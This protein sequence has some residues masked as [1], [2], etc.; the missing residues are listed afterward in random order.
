GAIAPFASASIGSTS[1]LLAGRFPA[2]EWFPDFARWWIGDAL[3][4]LTVMPGLLLIIRFLAGSSRRIGIP[5]AIKTI[6][7]A[8]LA[9]AGSYQIFHSPG[10]SSLLFGVLV[11]ILIAAATLGVFATR[12]TAFAIGL[13]AIW[14]AHFGNGA[15]ASGNLHENL[16]SLDLF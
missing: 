14:A 16:Q 4:I 5:H 3:G 7:F 15:F 10:E 12:F 6:L 13:S 9:A 2:A 11:M 8:I 1:Q